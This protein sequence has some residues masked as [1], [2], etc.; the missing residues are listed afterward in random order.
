MGLVSPRTISKLASFLLLAAIS[1]SFQVQIKTDN[2]HNHNSNSDT[3]IPIL[4]LTFSNRKSIKA[5]PTKHFK[6]GERVSPL[7]VKKKV[8]SINIA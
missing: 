2:G 6:R 8:I 5:E 7:P 4:D 1:T 3:A